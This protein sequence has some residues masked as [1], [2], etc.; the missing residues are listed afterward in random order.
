[1]SFVT[2]MLYFVGLCGLLYLLLP[3]FGKQK[4]RKA[5]DLDAVFDAGIHA[6][7]KTLLSALRGSRSAVSGT[8]KAL[9]KFGG[10]STLVGD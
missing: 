2:Y 1:M 3:G 6:V 10:G 5:Y 4:I 7:K 8:V 9:Y